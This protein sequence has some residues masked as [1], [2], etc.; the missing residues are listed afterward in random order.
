MDGLAM[1]EVNDLP[2]D[3]AR[4]REEIARL[5]EEIA[6]LKREQAACESKARDL[7]RREAEGEGVYAAEIHQNKQNKMRLLTEIKHRRVLINHLLMGL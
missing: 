1:M 5:E 7:M 4:R 2:E 6:S 3:P